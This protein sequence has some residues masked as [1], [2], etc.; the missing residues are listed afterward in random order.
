MMMEEEEEHPQTQSLIT[1]YHGN[2]FHQG[3]LQFWICSNRTPPGLSV[4]PI[5]ESSERKSPPV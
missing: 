4:G 1:R 3:H 2:C 5:P